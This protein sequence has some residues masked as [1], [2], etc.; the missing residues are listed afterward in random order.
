MERKPLDNISNLPS[1]KRNPS[2]DLER[3]TGQENISQDP[4]VLQ[5]SLQN[6]L[7]DTEEEVDFA[8]AS[9]VVPKNIAWDSEELRAQILASLPL[10]YRA[11]VELLISQSHS[12]NLHDTSELR[13]NEAFTEFSTQESAIS[14]RSQAHLV[15]P[16]GSLSSALSIKLHYSTFS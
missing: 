6:C 15:R 7:H 12:S 1:L 4:P 8:N 3:P 13:L 10:A 2:S 16:S 11:S 5:N 14:H 9:T